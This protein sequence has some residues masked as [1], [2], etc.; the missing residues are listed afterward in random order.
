M[1]ALRCCVCAPRIVKV[2]PIMLKRL[3]FL[4]ILGLLGCTLVGFFGRFHWLLDLFAHFR[5]QYA[6]IA[7]LFLLL[8]RLAKQRMSTRLALLILAINLVQIAPYYLP[9]PFI[10]G[11]ASAETENKP[12]L[13]VMTTN[14][15]SSIGN[16]QR[17]IESILAS[18]ADVVAI[19]ELNPTLAAQ[20]ASIRSE[21]PFQIL[22]TMENSHFGIALLSKIPLERQDVLWLEPNFTPTLYAEI[23][24]DNTPVAILATH[25]SPPILKYG[26]DLRT[27]RFAAL[28][29]FVS[30]TSIPT[31]VI[32]DLNATPW[33]HDMRN[34]LNN[35]RLHDSALGHG[36]QPTWLRR[37]YPFGIPI[38]YVL[39]SA[40]FRTLDH[41]VEP[42]IDS[43][44]F[45]VVVTLQ[46]NQ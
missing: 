30:A 12:T 18:G 19:I 43:D 42:S 5:V 24:V 27:Q 33:S 32:G 13:R 41:A 1:A 15:N 35:T 6:L 21:Y 34:L 17:A 16:E 7:L 39:A 2:Y 44:H 22:Q 37:Q 3:L 40:E 11:L 20:L 4:L 46:L 28:A 45:P 8:A 31:L 10:T 23:L 29:E 36:L 14:V 9:T 26:T 38:D 25:P